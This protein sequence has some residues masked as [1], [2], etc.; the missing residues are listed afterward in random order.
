MKEILTKEVRAIEANKT[1]RMMGTVIDLNVT[2]LQNP[3]Q[4]LD[5]MIARLE[6]YN[7]RF[8]ANDD[9]SELSAI[10]KNAGIQPVVVHRE[11]F[12]LIKIG[13]VHS[14]APDS[15][16]NIAIGPLVQTWRIG[17]DDA[18]V[19]TDEE[20]QVLL[21]VTDPNEIILDDEAQSV[22]LR[23]PG[24]KIDLGALAKGYIADRL[25]DYL[26]EVGAQSALINLGGNLVTFGPAVKRADLL[27]RIGI[28]NP[29]EL[30][31]QSQIILKLPQKSVVTS[32]IYERKLEKNGQTFHHIF[33]PKTGYPAET[34]LASLT[35][36]SDLSV[37][38]E[39][40]TTRLFGLAKEDIIKAINQEPQIEGL[41]ITK[42]GDVLYSDGLK[43]FL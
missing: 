18:T 23:T 28:Q 20:I 35:I 5:E 36:V 40:W 38:G 32:G 34:D 8:S 31:G 41:V 17:F 39:I 33:N 37:D 13:K 22:Y 43:Q 6:M 30:R 21:G 11:L 2:A 1:V 16:L 15:F 9:Q 24:M 10:N 14:V 4:I 12:E 29:V 26:D 3:E 42:T 7:Q 27:W 25:L 19:P